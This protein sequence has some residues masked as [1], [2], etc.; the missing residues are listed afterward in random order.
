MPDL[1]LWRKDAARAA[2]SVSINAPTGSTASTGSAT[3]AESSSPAEESG[4]PAGSDVSLRAKGSGGPAPGTVTVAV[5]VDAES[6]L[7]TTPAVA[8]MYDGNKY[9][10]VFDSGKSVGVDDGDRCAELYDG[11][12]GAGV[13]DSGMGAGAG[14]AVAFGGTLC[15]WVEVKGPGDD[16]SCAQ[17]AWIDTLVGAGAEAVLLRVEDTATVAAAAAANGR[18]APPRR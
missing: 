8:N 1:F 18:A 11:G 7:L 6:S 2:N 17:E 10:G 16:L 5:D 13:R 12:A 15:K 4:G 3:P 14:A 9:A